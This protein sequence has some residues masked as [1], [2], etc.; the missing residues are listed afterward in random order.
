MC[1]PFTG[2]DS[3]FGVEKKMLVINRL[4]VVL[5]PVLDTDYFSE[6]WTKK[7]GIIRIWQMQNQ[8]KEQVKAMYPYMFTV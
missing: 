7:G 8:Y 4:S 5:Y 2:N 1:G 3:K 6:C